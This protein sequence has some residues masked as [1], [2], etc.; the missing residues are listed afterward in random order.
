MRL[1]FSSLL[2]VAA[3]ISVRWLGAAQTDDAPITVGAS[4]GKYHNEGFDSKSTKWEVKFANERHRKPRR[5]VHSIDPDDR[6]DGEAAEH[7][8]LEA[9][10][11]D[12]MARL[13]LPLPASRVI[14]ELQLKLWVKSNRR[15]P[16]LALR[17]VFPKQV[18]PDTGNP[19]RTIVRGD[20]YE[21]VGEWQSMHCRTT[22]KLLQSGLRRLRNQL[23]RQ[24]RST[25]INTDG[26]YA[27]KALLI[28]DLSPGTTDIR[29]D[30]LNFGPVVRTIPV[31]DAEREP[32]VD[33][34]V[35]FRLG[36]IF[37]DDKPFFPRITPYH[38]EPISQLQQ[39]GFNLIWV[40]D[41]E[42][43]NVLEQLKHHRMWA[44]G[45]P[46]L[47]SKSIFHQASMSESGRRSPTD[48]TKLSSI[49]CWYLGT[50]M[51]RSDHQGLVDLYRATREADRGLARPF[52]ADVVDNERVY[53]RRID[54]LATSR[55]MIGTEFSYRHFRDLISNK[56]RQALPGT[57]LWT[58]I[59][60]EP[61]PA[62]VDW[63]AELGR[64][65]MVIEP[66]Q[67]R[68]QVY[69]ALA[70]GCRAIGYW[71]RGLLRTSNPGSVERQLQIAQL[72]L[73]LDLL[74]DWLSSGQLDAQ[75]RV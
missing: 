43:A 62:H 39:T 17:V 12:Q 63:R 58:W 11:N 40:P 68:L 3:L 21:Q 29:T 46:S 28:C 26:A 10:G 23:R 19:L 15:G 7:I 2:L 73:E 59:H 33:I 1:A 75:Y 32:D 24:L 51:S 35:D 56:R 14:D 25:E 69:A 70:A 38:G 44:M 60:T 16:V 6:L 54:M 52:A 50:Q 48:L 8:R 4:T 30:K 55:H 53:S 74:G 57:F 65:P 37:V 64:E 13:E 66:E 71:K 31:Q 9:T 34:P 42:D 22:E 72:N 20:V 18:D 5:T 36:R 27:D 49:L 67:I 61:V 47:D 45:S 41:T